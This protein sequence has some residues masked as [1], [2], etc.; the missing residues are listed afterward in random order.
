MKRWGIYAAVIA[1]AL[2]VTKKGSAGT[3]IARREPVQ[4]LGVETSAG[5]VVLRTDTG[6]YGTGESLAAAVADM[7][8]TAGGEIFLDTA[9]YLLVTPSAQKWLSELTELLRPACQVCLDSG[10]TDLGAAA[11]YLT[12]HEPGVTLRRY[13]QDACPLPVLYLKEGRMYLAES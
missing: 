6:Q 8:K 10:V 4:V 5:N 7:K 1:A 12:I 3:D 9:E 11:D 2:L 13:R